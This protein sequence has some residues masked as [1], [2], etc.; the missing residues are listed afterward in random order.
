MMSPNLSFPT[1]RSFR[2]PSVHLRLL[3]TIAV[4]FLLIEG[5]DSFAINQRSWDYK[6][7]F[8]VMSC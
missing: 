1:S 8:G 5:S 4:R 6:Y 3:L 7:V 2:R